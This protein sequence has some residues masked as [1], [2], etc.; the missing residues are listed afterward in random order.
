LGFWVG[1]KFSFLNFVHQR[2]TIEL[3]KPKPP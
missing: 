2:L 3:L 1:S